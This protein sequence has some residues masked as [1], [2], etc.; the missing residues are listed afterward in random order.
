[1]YR[2]IIGRTLLLA[3]SHV[4]LSSERGVPMNVAKASG[5]AEQSPKPA[6]Q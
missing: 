1:M 5:V 4:L 3:L 2:T 6:I